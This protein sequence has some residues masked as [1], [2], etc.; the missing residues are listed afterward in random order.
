MFKSPNKQLHHRFLHFVVSLQSKFYTLAPTFVFDVNIYCSSSRLFT[1]CSFL[2]S[3]T[4]N[5]STIIEF[6]IVFTV[7]LASR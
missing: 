1:T 2:E 6:S 7:T 4:S 3:S 5:A